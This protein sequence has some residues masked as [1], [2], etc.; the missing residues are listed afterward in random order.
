MLVSAA[1]AIAVV[2]I[3]LVALRGH[4]RAHHAAQRPATPAAVQA[5]RRRL[6]DIVSVLSRPRTSTDL[7]VLRQSGLLRNPDPVL[8]GATVDI[9]SARV[10][11]IAPWGSR[12][13]L[14]LINP[15]TPAQLAAFK[16]QFPEFPS[17]QRPPVNEERL[18][19]WVDHGG[20]GGEDA[21]G[22]QAGGDWSITGAGRSFAGGSTVT[23]IYVL[24]PDAVAKVAFYSP[25]QRVQSGGPTYRHGLTV[26]V[27]VHGN[28][29]AAEIHR[30][31]CAGPLMIWYAADGHVIKRVGNFVAAQH[32]PA[33]P[34]PSPPTAL[35]TPRFAGSGDPE[36]GLG[37]AP[38]R[39]PEHDLRHHL[40]PADQRRRLP[41]RL[42]VGAERPRVP[43]REVHLE[44]RWRPGRRPR[45]DLH[46]PVRGAGRRLVLR[47]LPLQRRAH[48]SRPGRRAQGRQGRALRHGIVRR[49]SVS[50]CFTLGSP[51]R[52]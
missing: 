14:A 27:P 44:S 7:R 29:A 52:R 40:P 50:L 45:A 9:A 35:L 51:C 33:P 23:R 32:A 19:M 48:R 10:A 16:K 36:P 6:L 15:P 2:V 47:H 34:Q 38:Q 41:V 5:S 20:G 26:T 37:R 4:P 21:A 43:A 42:R 1:V 31:C 28:I 18:T 11:A 3:A 17:A 12:V 13:L 8:A 46:L 24:V 49:P 30:Q 39:R 25:P 22:I